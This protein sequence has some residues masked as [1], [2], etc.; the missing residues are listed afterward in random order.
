LSS[1]PAAVKWTHIILDT[2]EGKNK[3]DTW[4]MKTR[5]R[6]SA[7]QKAQIV[8]ELLKEEKT[9][10]QIATEYGV[11]PNQLHRWKKQGLEG[12]HRLFE[13]DRKAEQAK[14]AEHEQQLQALYAEIGKLTT[15]LSWIKKNL[16]SNLPRSERI[17]ML[18]RTNQ[19]VPLAAQTEILD[20]SRSSLYYEP[21]KPSTLEIATK[22]RI[23]ELYTRFPVYGSRRITAVLRKDIVITRKTVQS[24][25]HEIGIA[26]ICPGPNLSKPNPAHKI[27]PY[28]LR[29]V[30]SSHP[31][32]IWG[33][34]ITYIRLRAGWMYLV[35]G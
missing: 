33:I 30:S 15:Q 2:K 27:Y 3:V 9:V 8:L 34:D 10:S 18:E 19:E 14:A 13:D 26:G 4:A 35:A 32:H 12:F 21:V 22:H 28:L 5:I 23:D 7:Q 6:H 20:L 16:A 31:N 24:Y 17:A 29:N 1:K 25:M 11:H